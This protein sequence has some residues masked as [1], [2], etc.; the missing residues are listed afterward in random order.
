MVAA[1]I[2]GI[3]AGLLICGLAARSYLEAGRVL[4]EMK[5]LGCGDE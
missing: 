1:L 2:V 3:I 4:D 5:A